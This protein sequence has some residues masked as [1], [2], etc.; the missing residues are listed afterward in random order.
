MQPMQRLV[1]K[2]YEARLLWETKDW[3]MGALEQEIKD[4]LKKRPA[5]AE[6]ALSE[7]S[8]GRLAST[9]ALVPEV[10]AELVEELPP[11]NDSAARK[12]R[13]V[14]AGLRV[15][16][17]LPPQCGQNPQ[18]IAKALADLFPA[19]KF[20]M[21]LADALTKQAALASG[22]GGLL[23]VFARSVADRL[24][25]MPK[26]EELV[27][28]LD[29]LIG[30]RIAV[31]VGAVA[32]VACLAVMAIVV[33]LRP[34]PSSVAVATPS[35]PPVV[36]VANVGAGG[37]LLAYE[38]QL[39]LGA[40]AQQMG[41]KQPPE[42]LIPEKPLPG[43]KLAPDCDA[44]L[45]EKAINGGCWTFIFDVKPPCG[46]LFREGNACYRPIAVDPQKPVGLEPEPPE[47][48]K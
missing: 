25:H 5:L 19:N 14:E 39:L 3:S 9:E 13:I 36:I 17:G 29:S 21:K 35:A 30:K 6:S 15:M 44:S 40:L 32:V 11:Q 8:I 18:A 27:Q 41:Q 10:L 48:E 24:P 2:W 33:L 16:R 23:D 34:G 42:R 20:A 45:G 37:A 7:T 43:Q 12:A 26:L 31:A 28:R 47:R 46:R 1:E 38:Q 4:Q 22:N